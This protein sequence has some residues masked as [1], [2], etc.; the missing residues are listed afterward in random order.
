MSDSVV[1]DRIRESPSQRPT[2]PV[3]RYPSVPLQNSC[4]EEQPKARRPA[5]PSISKRRRH[6]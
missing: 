5:G 6:I 2:V 4:S 1:P 3:I